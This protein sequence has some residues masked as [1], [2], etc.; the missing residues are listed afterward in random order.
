[1]MRTVLIA[2][3]LLMADTAL[4][5]ESFEGENLLIEPPDSETYETYVK[6]EPGWASTMW[7]DVETKGGDTI[8]VYIL[9]KYRDDLTGFRQSQ[10]QPGQDSCDRFDSRSLDDTDRNGYKSVFWAT[11]CQLGDTA[12]KSI[13]L[14]IQGRDSFYHVR[15]LW[16]R[17]VS[18]SEY[19]EWNQKLAATSLC[20]ARRKKK[21]P[22]PDGFEKVED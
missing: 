3:V 22:C 10:D 20:D 8:T 4:S 2:W 9:S 13:Q 15:K 7:V 17:E 11:E 14:A 16:K 19:A 6:N 5:G 18:E 21:H 1:M 12:I